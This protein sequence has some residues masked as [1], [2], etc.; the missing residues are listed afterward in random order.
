MS[1]SF[2]YMSAAVLKTWRSSDG[3]CTAATPFPI[4]IGSSCIEVGRGIRFSKSFLTSDIII[5]YREGELQNGEDGLPGVYIAA[6]LCCQLSLSSHSPQWC[7]LFCIMWY[8]MQGVLPC[9]P[10]GSS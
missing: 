2:D 9:Q 4:L 6:A 1:H 10:E 8:K 3:A 7:H 5:I